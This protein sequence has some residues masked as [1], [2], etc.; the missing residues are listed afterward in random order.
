[1]TKKTKLISF[2]ET[3]K[4]ECKEEQARF[5]GGVIY[6]GKDYE[7]EEKRL[8]SLFE[9]IADDFNKKYKGEINFEIQFPRNF[10]MAKE[11]NK[12][13]NFIVRET[14]N[15]LEKSEKYELFMFAVPDTKSKENEVNEVTKSNNFSDLNEP[16]NLYE[17]LAILTVYNFVF[18]S[19]DRNIEKNI[20]KLPT[21]TLNKLGEEASKKF[22]EADNNY[23]V[24]TNK[25]TF[26][27][28]ISTKI[29]EGNAV[30]SL[31]V[32]DLELKV[33]SIQYNE[34]DK[35]SSLFLYLSD[36]VCLY[37]QQKLTHINKNKFVFNSSVI[38][39]LQNATKL[40]ITFWVYD[41]IDKIFKKA[42][43]AYADDNL[44]KTYSYLYDIE[45]I[46]NEYGKYYRQYWSCKL[47][48]II[49][50]DYLDNC[51]KINIFQ[52]NIY[53]D[54]AEIEYYMRDK[55]DYARGEY[56]S[57]KLIKI[58]E[59]Y[60]SRADLEKINS[61]V[62]KKALYKLYDI[63]LRVRNHKSSIKDSEKYLKKIIKLK[64]Y[65]PFE[66][67]MEI[68][69]RG[70]QIYFNECDFERI[71]ELYE[72]ILADAEK[73]KEY[74]KIQTTY[75]D[76]ILKTLIEKEG[77]SCETES[78]LKTN[79]YDKKEIKVELLGKMYSTLG[80]AY[81]F[82]ENYKDSK[83]SF[84]KAL[85]EFEKESGNYHQTLGYLIHLF[86]SE[87][88]IREYKKHLLEFFG[89][90]DIFE[91]VQMLL[92]DDIDQNRYDIF[93]W[94]KALNKF[95][96]SFE[97]EKILECLDLLDKKLIETNYKKHPWQLI[98]KYMY[99]NCREF[100]LENEEK[101]M[102]K[103][104]NYE[105]EEGLIKLIKLKTKY[106]FLESKGK[107]ITSK[108]LSEIINVINKDNKDIEKNNVKKYLDEKLVYMYD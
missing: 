4:F 71:I 75:T 58:I 102:K 108:F 23:F 73:I 15:Y 86:I 20:F 78:T 98:Y 69:N 101:Y 92:E 25:N 28:A 85:N 61:Q 95:I 97:A 5:I 55:K 29:Y 1:M 44:A 22:A 50:E 36:I 46:D 38:E 30:N 32:K 6:K 66:E 45:I 90:E 21:R 2:D 77:N 63:Q 39:E 3:G 9:K 76:E 37:L 17:R 27:A 74:Y 57:E 60:L 104:T 40:K 26:K 59:C 80:Q 87:D 103:A 94:I 79:K 68:L 24:N 13:K 105:K 41:E 49:K 43:E 91:Q 53:K 10:H 51:D 107:S 84:E 42:I 19:L 106:I 52:K 35:L 93:I 81:A 89:N 16:G 8:K 70:V 72:I 96:K 83:E 11:I 65:I 67:Y 7:E 33:E 48:N 34:K 47:K 88:N 31:A 64:K 100:S 99:L 56:V 82:E 14:I 54:I 18:Y 62:L 12:V